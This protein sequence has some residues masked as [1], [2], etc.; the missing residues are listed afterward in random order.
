MIDTDRLSALLKLEGK[1]GMAKLR[2]GLNLTK[3]HTAICTA[4]AKAI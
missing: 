3:D 4:K 1:L 2:V